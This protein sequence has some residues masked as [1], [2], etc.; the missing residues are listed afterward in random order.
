MGHVGF[1]FNRRLTYSIGDFKTDKIKKAP[2]GAFLE[3]NMQVMKLHA[4][5]KLVF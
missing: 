2:Q 1:L 3:K 5:E 4:N